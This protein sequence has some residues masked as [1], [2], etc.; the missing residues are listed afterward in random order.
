MIVSGDPR[1]HVRRRAPRGAMGLNEGGDGGD[2]RAERHD[3]AGGAARHG[4]R[5]RGQ[6]RGGQC[7]RIRTGRAGAARL[8][9]GRAPAP[10]PWA[11]ALQG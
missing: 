7:R 8:R 11:G 3:G 10:R 1:Q 4:S 9:P 5:P 2:R 6:Q